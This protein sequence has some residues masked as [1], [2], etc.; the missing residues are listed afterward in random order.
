MCVFKW[1]IR[2]TFDFQ[3]FV[4]NYDERWNDSVDN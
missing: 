3:Q 1:H 2:D 4:R